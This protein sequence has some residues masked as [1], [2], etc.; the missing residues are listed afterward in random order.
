MRLLP[1]HGRWGFWKCHDRLRLHGH[2]ME[3]QAD[4]AGVLRH[5][6]QSAAS[7][8]EAID[9]TGCSRWT[10]RCGPMKSGHWTS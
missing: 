4:L 7:C 2:A 10:H 3:S 9:Q 8:E 5:G 1:E 6:A